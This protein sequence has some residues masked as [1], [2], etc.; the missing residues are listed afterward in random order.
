MLKVKEMSYAEKYAR[1]MD[2][3]K[4]EETHLVPFVQKNLGDQAVTDIKKNLQDVF[5]PIQDDAS[6]EQKYKTAYRNWVLSGG[7]TFAFIRS[8]LGEEGIERFIQANVDALK[9]KNT[10][11]ALYL[12]KV[13]RFFAPGTAFSMTTKNM[14]YQLQWLGSGSEPQM[15]KSRLTLNIPHCEILDYPNHEDMCLI[16]CQKLYP[17]WVAEQFKVNMQY[18]RQDKSCV[19]TLTPLK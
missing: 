4:F 8:R 5:T 16:G 7:V 15:S 13:I 3:L 11:I 6:M 14:V 10:G 18:N 12:L 19:M 2:E 17:M 1:A 9:R